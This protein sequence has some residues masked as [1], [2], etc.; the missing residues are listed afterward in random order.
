MTATHHD[1]PEPHDVVKLVR[2]QRHS[3]DEPRGW[4]RRSPRLAVAWRRWFRL[5]PRLYLR[6]GNPD[7]VASVR[8]RRPTARCVGRV[9]VSCTARTVV[10]RCRRERARA[11]P[12]VWC[13]MTVQRRCLVCGGLSSSSRCPRH[14]YRAHGTT[15]RGYGAAYQRARAA[16]LAARPS[17]W[18]CGEPATTADHVPPLRSVPNPADWRG[19]L[20]PA[21]ER[22]NYG[23][24]R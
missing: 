20:R 21:C 1:R 14:D 12:W 16:L 22:C 7:R 9:I 11:C 5:C 23:R 2:Q 18:R 15:A 3:G 6:F 4:R 8:P 24:H 10:G 19:V 13:A 17:C